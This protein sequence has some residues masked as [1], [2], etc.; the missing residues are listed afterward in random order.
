MRLVYN[1]RHNLQAPADEVALLLGGKAANLGQMATVLGLRVPP[2]FVIT[3]EACRSYFRAGWP[4]EL[5]E[6]I[7]EHIAQVEAEVGRRFAD[8]S[9]PLLVS[10]RSGAPVSMP[11]MMDTILNLGLTVETAEGLAKVTGRAAFAQD[12]LLRFEKM[13]NSVVGERPPASPHGQLRAAIEAVFQSWNSERARAFREVEGIP[14]DLGTAVTIQAMV[15]GNR[16]DD[17]GSG[18]LFT[19]NPSTGEH[20]PYGDVIFS[21]Q[22]EDVVAGTH[23]TEPVVVLNERQPQVASE[24]WRSSDVLERHFSDMCDIEFTIEE[25]VL[26]LLQVRAGKRSARAAL[27]IAI[28]MAEDPAFPLTREQAVRRVLPQ[29]ANPPKS[30]RRL[31]GSQHA[32]TRGLPASPG[33]ACGQVAT[34]PD[35][36]ITMAA[37]GIPVLLVRAETSP[38]DVPAMARAR[39]VLTTR[40]GLASHAAVVARGWGI[41]AVVGAAEVQII[42]PVVTIGGSVVAQ[43]QVV[44]I[45]G[46]TGEVF[47]GDI[48]SEEE[49]VAPEAAVLLGWAK[50]LGVQVVRSDEDSQPSGA[51]SALTEV[52]TV[53]DVISW[54]FIKTISDS[55]SLAGSLFCTVEG[56]ED[57]LAGIEVDGLVRRSNGLTR[58][59]DSGIER[60]KSQLKSDQERFG[61][62][63][64]ID[65]FVPLD[66]RMKSLV[67]AW[68]MRVVEGEETVNDHSDQ[69][70]DVRVLQGLHALHDDTRAWLRSLGD[71]AP[72]A[73]LYIVRFDRAIAAI[74]A[75]DRRFVASPRVDSFHSVWFEL[76]EDLIVL[77]GRTREDEVAAG[78][79]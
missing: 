61:G 77:A 43:G 44:S 79:A 2:G 24:L 9:D 1:L 40:G 10:V 11:G 39:G 33:I 6:Q 16:G 51:G 31:A 54:L 65:A 25:G 17:S 64:A 19:R 23:H 56:L 22:G 78:R 36:A 68:Q 37:A 41:P 29:L 18:V 21:A 27:R 35:Q 72:R 46:A 20:A 42:G 28:E 57:V 13:Y 12:C 30:W 70:Y 76:H 3:T 4:Q 67:T 49:D 52:P 32:A 74:D 53:E 14:E 47:L 62:G 5:D 8:A 73:N 48:G 58:L 60:A 26:W 75:S 66:K 63:A 71:S 50:T 59:S 15:F 7:D 45:D 38:E 34:T 55:G 69:Q